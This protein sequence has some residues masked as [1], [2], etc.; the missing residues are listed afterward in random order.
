MHRTEKHEPFFAATPQTHIL[1]KMKRF[2]SFME[3]FS[4]NSKNLFS[5]LMK[6]K[7]THKATLPTGKIGY[8]KN[9]TATVKPSGCRYIDLNSLIHSVVHTYH[10]KT[11]AAIILHYQDMKQIN[12]YFEVIQIHLYKVPILNNAVCN[13]EPSQ[14]LAQRKFPPLPNYKGSF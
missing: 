2:F 7:T 4:E 6:M 11:T 1:L 5:V 8:I 13:A 14:N 3:I 10:P 12:N 9:P